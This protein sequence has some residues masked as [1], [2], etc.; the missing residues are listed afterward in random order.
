M[1]PVKF[2]DKG[3]TGYIVT[4]HLMI[5]GVKGLNQE[6]M[7]LTCTPTTAHNT[8]M[9]PTRT[10]RALSTSTVKSM[11]PGDCKNFISK[12][13]KIHNSNLKNQGGLLDLI[14]AAHHSYTYFSFPCL[15]CV[16][17]TPFIF[18]LIKCF[19]LSF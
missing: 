7:T 18:L 17:S 3:N 2:I 1:L 9:T 6:T 13:E 4:L 5:L 11:R 12:A 16:V 19:F 10:H 15:F 14:G 8:R